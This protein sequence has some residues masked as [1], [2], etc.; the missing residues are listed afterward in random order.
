MLHSQR[1]TVFISN[2]NMNSI[3]SY[4]RNTA[5]GLGLCDQWQSEWQSTKSTAELCE[6]FKRGM[7]FCVKHNYPSK[8]DVKLNF[9]RSELNDNKVY[10][11]QPINITDTNGTYV[12]LG[13]CQGHLNLRPYSA[14]LIYLRHNS[15]IKIESDY[16]CFVNVFLYD[17]S[18][19]EI[20]EITGSTIKIRDCRE[21]K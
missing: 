21:K 13:D 15:K 7:G 18:D 14:A 12:F 3:N 1:K 2:R 6:M 17:D 8:D 20:G 4:L 11:D 19:V 5:I 10:I 16:E 9:H